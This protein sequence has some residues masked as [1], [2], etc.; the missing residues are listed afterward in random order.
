MPRLI[1]A[2][3]RHGDYHQLSNTPSAHQPFP[4][5]ETGIEQS[6][7]A[8]FELQNI[9]EEQN[10]LLHPSI[11]CSHLLR[12]WQTAEIF[13]RYLS[14]PHL[15]IE[16]FPSLAERSVGHSA[17]LT[18]S[19]IEQVVHIDPRY[20]DLPENWKSNSSFCLP[21]EG[22]ESLLESGQR[23]ADHIR[24]RMLCIRGQTQQDTVKIFVGHG[25]A[26]RHAAYHLGILEFNQI[27]QL[28]MYHCSPIFL[29]LL[30]DNIWIQIG[31]EWKIR[32]KDSQYED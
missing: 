5:N 9:I 32:A 4:L 30:P 3:Y 12:A 1:A 14:M 8:A 13:N 27:A 28:S 18:I 26:F 7:H 20:T 10:W 29:E 17:N 31:G 21:F 11:D 2:L 22:A 16:E 6:N 19:Q 23:V 24:D 15:F 25:A